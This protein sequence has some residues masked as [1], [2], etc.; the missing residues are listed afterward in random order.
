MFER[1]GYQK[2]EA[3]VKLGQLKEKRFGQL[4]QT[5]AAAQDSYD[6]VD[7]EL[8][9]A[10]A[11]RSGAQ[12]SIAL[13]ED[14]LQRHLIKAP[15]SG[16]VSRKQTEL[17][18]WVS[19][20]DALLELNEVAILR[21]TAPLPQHLFNRVRQGSEVTL[22]FTA[23]PGEKI[24]AEVSRKVNVANPTS[25]TLPLLIDL[26]NPDNSLAPGMS[27]DVTVQLSEG[28]KEVLWVPADALVQ[29]ASGAI[30]LWK[31][32]DQNE[33][34]NVVPVPVKTGRRRSG[35]VEITDGSVSAGDRVVE[36]GNERMRPGLPIRIIVEH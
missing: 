2:A 8:S 18:S 30:L 10:I 14:E 5:Q 23:L 13:A 35:Q 12:A 11:E 27:V 7:A 19:P 9:R 20:G 4:I 21:I 25:R 22:E 1:A 29:Q 28:N 32:V 3:G 17:G 15:F 6:L 16:V 36:Q 31:V 34:L 24:S 26:A 33:Q